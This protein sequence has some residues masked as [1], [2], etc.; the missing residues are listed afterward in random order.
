MAAF[1]F[2]HS[3][4]KTSRKPKLFESSAPSWIPR[5][6]PFTASGFAD[7]LRCQIE[8]GTLHFFAHAHSIILI[9]NY[10]GFSLIFLQTKWLGKLR[11]FLSDYPKFHQHPIPTTKQSPSFTLTNYMVKW[12]WR[13]ISLSGR[14]MKIE[15]E[16]Y[17]NFIHYS[18]NID[19]RLFLV[20]R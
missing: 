12:N 16:I 8:I 4:K 2:S 13:F 5:I 6:H 19:Y 14:C 9:P 10:Y 7:S 17:S 20:V 15:A 18:L 1:Y 3:K 11:S